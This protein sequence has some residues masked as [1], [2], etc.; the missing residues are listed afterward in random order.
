MLTFL[1]RFSPISSTYRYHQGFSHRPGRKRRSLAVLK[2]GERDTSKLDSYRPISNLPVLSKLLERIVARQLHSHLSEFNLLPYSQSGYRPH[3]STETAMLSVCSDLLSSIDAGKLCLLAQLD[4]SAAFDTVDHQTLLRRL[5]SSFG[6]CGPVLQWCSSFL[7]SRSRFVR[8]LNQQ[9][10][11]SP[12]PHGVP[13]GSVLGPLLFI[14]YTADVLRII[15]RHGLQAHAYAD[16]LTVYGSCSPSS[17]SE[18]SSKVE[19]CVHDLQKWLS[20]NKLRLNAAKTEALWCAS[21]RRQDQIPTTT[22]SV[23][24]LPIAPSTTIRSLGVQID[25]S[26]SMRPFI[27]RKT[28]TCF[29]ALRQIRSIRQSLS[30]QVLRSL[31]VSLV[32]SRLDYCASVLYGLPLTQLRRLQSVLNAGARLVT[33]TSS[34]EHITPT[35]KDLHWL[36]IRERIDFRIAL[37]C[38]QCLHGCAPAYLSDSL[39][40]VS[41]IPSRS[42]LRSASRSALF[43]PLSRRSTGSRAFPAA[44]ARIW[45]SLPSTVTHQPTLP[46]FKRSLKTTL[47]PRSFPL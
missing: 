30:P 33:G 5:E 38:F 28:A 34:R 15:D 44:A 43:V 4:L 37:L 2:K 18:L 1:R 16:D 26:L 3:H 35:L 12:S 46:S 17:A 24:S 23:D 31:V 7:H 14:L 29:A 27:A 19:T 10:S 39:L 21:I 42:H 40:P 36:R 32:H 45:N 9:S 13:Q 22:I 47:F 6:L 25:S 8:H 20:V 11:P 41:S